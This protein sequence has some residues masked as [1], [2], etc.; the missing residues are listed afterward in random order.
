MFMSPAKAAGRSGPGS[1]DRSAGASRHTGSLSSGRWVP[2][3]VNGAPA[4]TTARTTAR[5]PGSR[6]SCGPTATTSDPI[7]GSRDST[8]TTQSPSPAGPSRA[9]SRTWSWQDA[10]AT[11]NVPATV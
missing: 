5:R 11:A 7:T 9:T 4:S 2:T 6:G 1:A 3:T 8:A 10:R